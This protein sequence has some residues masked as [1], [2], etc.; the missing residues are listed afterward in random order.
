LHRGAGAIASRMS[1]GFGRGENPL[2]LMLSKQLA[3]E[4]ACRTSAG[5][6]V[7]EGFHWFS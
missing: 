6:H 4:T 7:N 3:G 2:L 5:A 1:D